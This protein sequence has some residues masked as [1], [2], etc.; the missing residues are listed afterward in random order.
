MRPQDIIAGLDVGSSAI[1]MAVAQRRTGEEDSPRIV[2]VAEVPAE[3]INRGVVTSIDDAVS[4]ISA[5]LERAERIV[6]VPIDRVWVGIAGSHITSQESRGVV[7][8]AK[9]SG[10]ISED[11]VERAIEAAR[12]V[13]TPPNYEI[14]HVIPK[15]FTVDGQRGIRDPIGMTG[16]RLEVDTQIVQG[17][18]AQIKNITKAIYRTQLQI[19]D[20]V[21]SI[22]ATA[23]AVL[24]SRSKQLG[25]VVIN[26]GR[27]TTALAVYEEGEIL[28]TAVLPVGSE[29]ITSDIA[30]GL[31]INIDAAEKI[32]L[33]YGT[34]QASDI[35][36][37]EEVDLGELVGSPEHHVPK[38][39]IAEII[40]AR[41][42]EILDKVDLEL[43]KI[44]RSGM[45]PAGVVLTGG[46]AKLPGMVETAKRKLRLPASIGYPTVIPAT[47]DRA[48][49]VAFSTAIGLVQWGLQVQQRAA[50]GR[51][52]LLSSTVS[53]VTEG[54]KKL[55]S[56]LGVRR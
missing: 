12:A 15:S 41:V 20:L 13:A 33:L 31:R 35:S 5:C 34:T 54:I 7:A 14:L 9:P 32:K 44:E 39:Y 46:G 21:L 45:L 22:L 50:G 26:V 48:N 42:E 4:S 17:L 52:N 3:G 23:E 1:R 38:K 51:T 25:S 55:F 37:R 43:K 56:R 16:V 19:E 27:S 29:H 8:V 53:G 36:K 18:S 10:E 30:I 47:V 24:P 49:D 28:H 11:D 6:G 40:E 2:G